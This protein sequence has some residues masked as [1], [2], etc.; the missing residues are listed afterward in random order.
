MVAHAETAFRPWLALGGTL[1]GRLQLDPALRE[2]AILRVAAIAGCNY[3]L[4]QHGPIATAVGVGSDQVEA[5]QKGRVFGPE[6]D[7]RETLIV[8]FVGEVIENTGTA[9][10][11]VQEVEDV[12]SARE[13]VEL[14][15][16]IAHYHGLALLLNTTGVQPD[17]PAGLALVEAAQTSPDPR[18]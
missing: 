13:V 17:P 15:L 4:V 5:L 16:V 1:L 18:G 10:A 2:L 14:L 8:R 12:L 9:A 11:L 7:E 6:F 3:E